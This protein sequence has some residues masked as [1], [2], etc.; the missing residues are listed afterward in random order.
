M[1][2]MIHRAVQRQRELARKVAEEEVKTPVKEQAGEK[3]APKRGRK[4]KR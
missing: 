1:S 4:N 2:M 3:P